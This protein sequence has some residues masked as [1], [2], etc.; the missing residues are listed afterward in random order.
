MKNKFT[1]HFKISFLTHKLFGEAI[2]I[3]EAIVNLL[4]NIMNFLIHLKTKFQFLMLGTFLSFIHL[5]F[6]II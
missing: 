4:N 1:F 2:V 6:Y 3:L 5:S